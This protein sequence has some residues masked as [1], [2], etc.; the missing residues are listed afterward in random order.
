VGQIGSENR[1]ADRRSTKGA[2]RGSFSSWDT[3]PIIVGRKASICQNPTTWSSVMFQAGWPIHL[4]ARTVLALAMLIALASLF[5]SLRGTCASASC[6]VPAVSSHRV[7][8]VSSLPSLLTCAFDGCNARFVADPNTLAKPDR[9]Q[10][11]CPIFNQARGVPFK[12]G[13][14][15]DPDTDASMSRV[16]H[17]WD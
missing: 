14:R 10:S 4:S 9:G 17:A 15:W 1:F 8:I 7:H 5:L 11:A 2:R 12:N 6:D 16:Q 13:S 3:A